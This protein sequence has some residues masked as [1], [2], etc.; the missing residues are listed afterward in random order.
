[1]LSLVYLQMKRKKLGNC[2][3]SCSIKNRIIATTT[4][5]PT[6]KKERKKKER[7]KERKKE[8]GKEGRK[9]NVTYS[10]IKRSQLDETE[11]TV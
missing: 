11:S 8:G 9:E 10:R 7:K 6:P 5:N 2:I 3:L 4:T 1:M